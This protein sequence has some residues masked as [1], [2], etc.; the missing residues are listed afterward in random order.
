MTCSYLKSSWMHYHMKN[1]MEHAKTPP[2]L[3]PTGIPMVR[4]G[5]CPHWGMGW[6]GKQNRTGGLPHGPGS[7]I[8]QSKRPPVTP[9][10]CYQSWEPPVPG[11]MK[12]HCC[13]LQTGCSLCMGSHPRPPERWTRP[14][15]PPAKGDKKKELGHKQR[16]FQ[17]M[18]S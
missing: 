17:N 18:I 6:R 13:N 12:P 8:A 5:R 7:H 15:W 14:E 16:N 1:Y 3:K 4:P 9:E 11:W 2:W 10:R